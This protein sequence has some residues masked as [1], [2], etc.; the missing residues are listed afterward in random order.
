MEI[1]AWEQLFGLFARV[2]RA[3]GRAADDGALDLV[4]AAIVGINDHR[5]P[6]GG[7]QGRDIFDPFR[8]DVGGGAVTLNTASDAHQPPRDHGLPPV[9]LSRVRAVLVFR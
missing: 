6:Q 9:A 5:P 1:P 3:C 4:G 8:D 2:A 7:K